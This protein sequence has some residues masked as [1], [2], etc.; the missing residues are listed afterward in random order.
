[1][2]NKV[3]KIKIEGYSEAY[4]EAKLCQ[5]VII[6]AISKRSLNRNITIKGGVVRSSLSD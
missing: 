6:N 4:A 1:M 3:E 5:D 2:M